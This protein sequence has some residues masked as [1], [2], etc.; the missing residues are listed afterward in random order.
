DFSDQDPS[1]ETF[2]VRFKT[3]EVAAEFLAAVKQAQAGLN[4]TSPHPAQED[5]AASPVR[6][7]MSSSDETGEK[8]PDFD[9]V[10]E[11]KASPDQIERARKLQLPD[12]FYLY[13]D[14]E[15]SCP[16]CV[17][18][19][20]DELVFKKLSS[21]AKPANDY[22]SKFMTSHLFGNAT[23]DSSASP[24]ALSAASSPQAGNI[25]ATAFPP[26]SSFGTPKNMFG[27][28]PTPGSA[29]GGT[30]SPG[31]V[32]GSP[33]PAASLPS[34]SSLGGAQPTTPSTPS[35]F[36]GISSTTPLIFGA[37]KPT[38]PSVFGGTP[39]TTPSVFGGTPVKI[40][41]TPSTTPSLFGG[42]QSVFGGAPIKKEATPS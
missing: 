41:G 24:L 38:T 14:A 36:G 6:T 37:V 31:S 30:M 40:E 20:P 32:F 1:K 9:I 18:C 42:T 29:F 33:K 28:T 21:R 7:A 17:G 26:I 27:G 4:S 5:K 11:K 25:F 16:G 13:E 23:R 3:P 19:S 2:A 10:Y 35:L 15:S 34:A 12:N 22:E 8:S 39:S